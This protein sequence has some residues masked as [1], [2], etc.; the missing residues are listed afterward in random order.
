[1]PDRNSSSLDQIQPLESSDRADSFS[2][3]APLDSSNHLMF[4]CPAFR[5]NRKNR[6]MNRDE[7][8]IEFF[9]EVLQYRIDNEEE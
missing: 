8:L 9:Q 3:N 6:D 4:Y 2:S 7:D 1:M 5:K